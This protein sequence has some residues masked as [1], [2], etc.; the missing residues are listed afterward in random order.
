MHS[1]CLFLIRVPI[2]KSNTVED[3]HRYAVDTFEK[4][5]I[6]KHTDDN[7]WYDI[8]G[9]VNYNGEIFDTGEGRFRDMI[10]KWES[11]DKGSRWNNLID[12]SI[13]I[14][15]SFISF[16]NDKVF[17]KE[18][19]SKEDTIACLSKIIDEG[20]LPP[21]IEK[22]VHRLDPTALGGSIDDALD[23]VDWYYESMKNKKICLESCQTGAFSRKMMMPYDYSCF[24]LR[25]STKQIG[26]TRDVVLLVD[27]HT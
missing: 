1:I 21:W 6:A 15:Q 7:N 22:L 12:Y 5:Y 20:I 11:F 2:K 23:F 16:Q 8:M 17:L 26:N 4:K 3:A 9:S 27:M 13:K 24:D 25:T 18:S 10:E 19:S 14:V